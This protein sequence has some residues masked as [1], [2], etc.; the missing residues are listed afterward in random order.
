[1]D[2]RTKE[3]K[4]WKR[5]NKGVGDIIEDITTATGIKA[6]VKSVFGDDCGCDER[7]ETINKIFGKRNIK[8]LEPD[9]FEYLTTVFESKEKIK[10]ETQIKMKAIFERVFNVKLTSSCLSCSFISEIYK[11]LHKLCQVK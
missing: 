1:M 5:K 9:E 8:C 7:K 10:P 4:E 3:Y 6:V 11:P 2:K